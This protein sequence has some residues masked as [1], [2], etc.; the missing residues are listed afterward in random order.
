MEASDRESTLAHREENRIRCAH[1]KKEHRIDAL[2]LFP[3]AWNHLS[4]WFAASF[5][6]EPDPLRRKML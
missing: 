2:E 3:L 5:N 1:F 6:G 4:S